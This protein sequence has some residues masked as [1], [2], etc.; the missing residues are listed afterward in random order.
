MILHTAKIAAG[1]GISRLVNAGIKMF[2]S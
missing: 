2:G 1:L